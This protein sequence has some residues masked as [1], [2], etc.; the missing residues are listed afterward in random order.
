MNIIEQQIA[1]IKLLIAKLRELLAIKEK[2]ISLRTLAETMAVMEGWNIP[3]SLCRRNHNPL[4]LR[5][6]KFQTGTNQ[7]FAVFKDDETGWT[8]AIWDLKAKQEGR[9]STGL[10]GSSTIKDLIF[11]WAPPS[12][13]ND[14]NNYLNFVCKKLG[15]N[16]SYKLKGFDICD[17]C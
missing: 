15:I 13:N 1:I 12:D 3:N 16:E 6:S 10:N 11:V 7:G 4:N 17:Y 5:Y 9:T 8:A 2:K 14:T